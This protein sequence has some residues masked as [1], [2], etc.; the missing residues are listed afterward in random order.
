MLSCT[1]PKSALALAIS[2]L[3]SAAGSGIGTPSFRLVVGVGDFVPTSAAAPEAGGTLGGIAGVTV[4]V[5]GGPWAH[6]FCCAAVCD[7]SGEGALV[8]QCASQLPH[9][10]Q[11]GLLPAEPHE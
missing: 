1:Q 5:D 2:A 11:C 4:G 6:R 9:H 3:V 10:F 8:S 7:L